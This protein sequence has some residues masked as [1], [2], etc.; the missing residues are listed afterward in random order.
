MNADIGAPDVWVTP[1]WMEY[2]V[3]EDFYGS[4]GLDT[5]L[6]SP[7]DVVFSPRTKSSFA[8][9][10]DRPED[11]SDTSMD[12]MGEF[13]PG[14][15]ETP[16]ETK[17]ACFGNK[18][19]MTTI[20]ELSTL[21]DEQKE[22]CAANAYE[23][24]S[25]TMIAEELR[26]KLETCLSEV[27]VKLADKW[28]KYDTYVKATTPPA[29][30]QPSLFSFFC[31][32][33]ADPWKHYDGLNRLCEIVS[34]STHHRMLNQ[35]T[36]HK[37]HVQRLL[38]ITHRRHQ[39]DIG[40]ASKELASFE[41]IDTILQHDLKLHLLGQQ[42][43]WLQHLN[44]AREQAKKDAAIHSVQ[45]RD[46]DQSHYQIRHGKMRR[47]LEAA[48][49]YRLI[50][51]SSGVGRSPHG[52]STIEDNQ[53]N[54]EKSALMDDVLAG[55]EFYDEY[56]DLMNTQEWWSVVQAQFENL[57]FAATD[58]RICQMVDRV[59][60]NGAALACED[61]VDQ[62]QK[63]SKNLNIYLDLHH[64]WLK[65][66]TPDHVLEFIEAVTLRVRH[67]F[68]ILDDINKS[69][70][71][72]MQRTMF[73]RLVSLC[74]N[75]K[76]LQECSRKDA[77]WRSKQQ[78][79]RAQQVS[80]EQFGVTLKTAQR[81]RTSFPSS[82][83]PQARSAFS[84]MGSLVPCDLLEE[85]LHGV[86]VLHQEAAV[87]FGTTRIA[88]DTFFPLL[89]YVLVHADIPFVHAHLYLLEHYALGEM[90]DSETHPNRNGEESYYVYCMHAAVEA[91]CSLSCAPGA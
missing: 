12:E 18:Y 4:A 7:Y 33:Q 59:C 6:E 82:I 63:K 75:S 41:P 25:V 81:I 52:S 14:L 27:D 79:L 8:Y 78:R 9:K 76:T 54:D 38:N 35:L 80:M 53:R 86:I 57:V 36:R 60:Y 10:E 43:K 11:D 85:M 45:Y 56:Y 3:L 72:F 31:A 48:S 17:P 67:E 26:V 49:W 32:P 20:K 19:R 30:P 62:D 91:I 24:D 68:G 55:E 47:L 21:T 64:A 28:K 2:P 42:R 74:F 46:S 71:I 84:A 73:P 87:V 51:H 83:F 40:L 13:S 58:N 37:H 16:Q 69:L 89:S 90:T 15:V 70:Y 88:V 23:N 61:L 66:P 5:E 39:F 65:E 44:R 50:Q 34:K 29:P 1:G 77:L 22:K